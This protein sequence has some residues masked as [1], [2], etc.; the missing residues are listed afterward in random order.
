LF[1]SIAH[2]KR[3]PPSHR[4]IYPNLGT[5]AIDVFNGSCRLSSWFCKLWLLYT[6]LVFLK[7]KR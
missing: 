3:T 2:L 1:P 7:G 6:S 5:A 4:Q